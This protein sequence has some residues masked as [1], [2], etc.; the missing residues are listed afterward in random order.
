VGQSL[1]VTA[2]AEGRKVARMVD[3]HLAAVPA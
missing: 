1:I 2:M 3:R